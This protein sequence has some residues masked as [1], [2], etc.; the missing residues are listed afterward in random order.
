MTREH[1]GSK[2]LEKQLPAIPRE[3]FQDALPS[4]HESTWRYI[5]ANTRESVRGLDNKSKEL[6]MSSSSAHYYN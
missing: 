1:I 3:Q 5:T 2:T 4:D 6:T